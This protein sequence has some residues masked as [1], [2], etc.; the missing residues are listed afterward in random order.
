MNAGKDAD[1]QFYQAR[2]ARLSGS[3]AEAVSILDEMHRQYHDCAWIHVKVHIELARAYFCLKDYPKVAFNIFVIIFA[4]P[5]SW[6]QRYLGLA[7]KNI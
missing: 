7:R 3:S 4:P 2:Q 6:V 5:A 1:Q